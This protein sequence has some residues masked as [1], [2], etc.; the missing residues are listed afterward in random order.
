M[1]TLGST[2][3]RVGRDWIY[4]PDQQLADYLYHRLTEQGQDVF[5]DRT[6]RTGDDWLAEIDQKI[7]ESDFLGLVALYT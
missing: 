3:E 1:G 6:L 4:R 2:L 5:I 7:K